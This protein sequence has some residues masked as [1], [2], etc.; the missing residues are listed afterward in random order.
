[1]TPASSL[2]QL[3][4]YLQLAA[5]KFKKLPLKELFNAHAD[6]PQQLSFKA[7]AIRL[8]ASK[9]FFD[10]EILEQLCQVASNKGLLAERDKMFSG[11][12]IN[13]TEQ[14]AVLH[15]ALRN[16]DYLAPHQPELCQQI[17][18]T[19]QR[20][21]QFVDDVHCGKRCGYTGK[22]FT[23]VISIGIGGSFFGPKMLH[24]ALSDYAVS[25]LNCHY[26]ANID[27]EQIEQILKKLNPETTLVIVASKSWTT[28]ETQINAQAIQT[29]FCQHLEKAAIASHWVALTAK[30]N[31]ANE[32]GIADE[33]TFPLWDFVG[34]RYSVWSV[35]G[36]PLAL[37]IGRAH[38]NELLN[39]AAAQDKHF[40][41]TPL[42]RNLPVVLALIG[43]WQQ[44]Y[45]QLNNLMVLPYSH[46]LKALPA[47]LQQLDMESNGK[48][49]NNQGDEVALSGPIL[50]GAEGT[51]C[52]HSFMQL[53]HQGK[54]NAM[55]DFILPL[56]NNS[57]YQQHHRFMAANCFA[58][59]Q[60]LMLGKSLQQAEQELRESGLESTEAKQLAQHKQMP[61]NTA[62]NML[63]IDDIS[64]FSLGSLLA[65]Y[66]HK[67]FVQGVLFDINSFDQWGVELGKQLGKTVLNA[68]DSD[69]E[70][71]LDP[72][73]SALV[74]LFKEHQS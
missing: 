71:E 33:L 55:I 39:G 35:I 38:F 61:G 47:Y 15:T 13:R 4:E 45:F 7:P 24:G 65:C 9:Q 50:W 63:L 29:W 18:D 32:F 20:M 43:Y 14:R 69:S 21:L 42:N 36:L 26:L 40:C 64:P 67:V 49:V 41:E 22:P 51:N 2:Q 72:S 62:S 73:T 10:S 56:K 3:D 52:Q 28:S 6:R 31:L 19:K 68:I 1:M 59:A 25:D 70:H 11:E 60:A 58:Q 57:Q 37:A 5:D 30:P 23:D 66:E 34:G 12:I 44:R 54:Q 27:G 16:S 8:D 17:E 74:S 53:F 48:R 46:A